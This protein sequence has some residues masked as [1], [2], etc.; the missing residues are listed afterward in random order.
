MITLGAPETVSTNGHK[1]KPVTM[2]VTEQLYEAN[3]QLLEIIDYGIGLDAFGAGTLPPQGARFDFVFEGRISGEKLNGTIR[4]VDYGIVRADGRFDLD[5][6]AQLTTDDGEKIAFYA[7]G[8]FTAPDPATGIG[9]VRENVKL[10]TASPRYAW[11]NKLHIWA[12]GGSNVTT[13]RLRIHG[14]IA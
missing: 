3:L 8:I 12:T 9:Q 10:T 14:Y 4:G 7:D 2:L 5:L 13:G 6:H 11:V 1:P